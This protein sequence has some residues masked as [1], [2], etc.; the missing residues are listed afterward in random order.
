MKELFG[1]QANNR[2]S[3]MMSA[4]MTC[5]E[6]ENDQK[7]S[8]NPLLKRYVMRGMGKLL[9]KKMKFSKY[10]P[11]EYHHDIDQQVIER[12]IQDLHDRMDNIMLDK[13]LIRENNNRMVL[14]NN[15]QINARLELTKDF[16]E[17]ND[18]M[19]LDKAQV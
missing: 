18:K 8:E 16:K 17:I 7:L 1:Q 5:P 3:N 15:K 6:L 11:D 14:Q 4:N 12:N 9:N 2:N 19:V 13:R 10:T